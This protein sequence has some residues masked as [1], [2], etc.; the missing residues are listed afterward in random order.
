V[1]TVSLIPEHRDAVRNGRD[2][3]EAMRD[4]DNPDSGGAKDAITP[5]NVC[6]VSRRI[7]DAVGSSMISTS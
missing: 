4:A 3:L 7:K 2:F 1:A 6:S 5:N